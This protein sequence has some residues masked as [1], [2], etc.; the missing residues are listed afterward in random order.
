METM[1]AECLCG[2]HNDDWWQSEFLNGN[3]HRQ[4]IINLVVGVSRP[5]VLDCGTTFHPDCDGLDCPS[6]LS[7]NL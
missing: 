7:D 3:Q 5:P 2:V 4:H 6:T 1:L